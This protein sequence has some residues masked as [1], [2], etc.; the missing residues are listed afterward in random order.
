MADPWPLF[1]LV[2]RTSRLELRLPRDD[3]LVA[4]MRVAQAGVHD[5][6]VMPFSSPWTDLEGAAF[7]QGFLRY[8][9]TT[10]GSVRPDAWALELAVFVDGAPVGCQAL[11]ASEFAVLREVSSGSW[12]GERFQGRGLGRD[13]RAAVLHLAFEGLGALVAST[14]AMA[15]NAAS[16]AVTERLGYERDGLESAAPRG[17]RVEYVRY[18][19]PRERW[20]ERRRAD[21][22]IVGLDR[23]RALLGA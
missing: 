21:I 16:S 1:D 5:P 19:L 17:E 9:W 7:E 4:L 6:A 8:H 20:L 3:E 2:V 13:M 15:G 18:R 10:R 22:E 11:M 12:L 14:S 23:C